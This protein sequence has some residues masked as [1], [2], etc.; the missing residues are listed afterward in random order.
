MS[1]RE[2]IK[3]ILGKDSLSLYELTAAVNDSGLKK[4]EVHPFQI[5]AVIN[6]HCSG[7]FL[8]RNGKISLKASSNHK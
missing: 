8:L 6:G 7:Q 1:L 3:I 2:V 4:K 5:S